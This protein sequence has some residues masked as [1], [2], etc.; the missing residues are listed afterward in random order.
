MEFVADLCRDMPA[1]K[2]A[3]HLGLSPATVCA[4]EKEILKKRLPPPKLDG[5]RVLLIDEKS[6]R[7]G[8]HY[9][10]VVMN[11]DTREVLFMAEGHKKETLL[12]FLSRLSPS[13]KASIKAVGIDR[14]GAYLAAVKEAL[15]DAD[16]VFDRF[17]IIQN[18]NGVLDEIRRSEYRKAEKKRPAMAKLIRGQRY[19]LFRLSENRTEAQTVKL[20]ALL[21]ANETLSK[22]HVLSGQL[23]LLWTYLHRGYAQRFLRNWV[24]MAEESGIDPLARFARGLWRNR[25]GIVNYAYHRVTSGPLEAMNGTIE[26][27]IR[28]ACGMQDIEYLF[29][30][31]R[32]AS[33]S[34]TSKL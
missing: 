3:E 18:L 19:N 28:R 29:L 14:G 4:Y 9:V 25:T 26:R 22:A 20:Q 27:L 21:S 1:R 15:P 8:H 32:Q 24:A 31:V 2:V 17:H 12:R 11:G 6:V 5:I 16:V 10:T 30:K 13:Q 33:L 7:R 23:R 34:N